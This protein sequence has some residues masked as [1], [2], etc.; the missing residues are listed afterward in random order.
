MATLATVPARPISGKKTRAVLTLTEA[1]TNYVRVW[2][3]AAPE[4]SK[5]GNKVKALGATATSPRV[6]VYEGQGGRNHP[7]VETFDK[8]GLYTLKAQEYTKGNAWGGGYLNDP[9]GAPT[10]TKVGSE[11]SLTLIVGERLVHQLGHGP[12]QATFVVWVWNDTIHETNTS[13]GY[14]ENTPGI[15]NPTSERAATAMGRSEVRTALS[16]FGGSGGSAIGNLLN[17]GT[18]LSFFSDELRVK[19]DAHLVAAS[20]HTANDTDNTATAE[21]SSTVSPEGLPQA[22]AILAR[23]MRNH[24]L[25]DDGEGPGSS[26]YHKVSGVEKMDWL[27]VP[28]MMSC[29]PE[30]APNMIGD[31]GRVLYDHVGGGGAPTVAIHGNNTTTGQVPSFTSDRLIALHRAFFLALASNAPTSAIGQGSL[32][33]RLSNYGFSPG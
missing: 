32:A 1:N 9:R 20:R 33:A 24:L 5:L 17:G 29:T 26:D 14:P 6:Q 4:G 12:D 8:G 7:W 22:L 31:L 21:L 10:E 2:C 18:L 19:F 3:T 27:N 28:I 15:V 11:A 16:A 23:K 13:N 30:T 25:N